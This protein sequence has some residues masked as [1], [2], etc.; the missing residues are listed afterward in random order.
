[1]IS[2]NI[3]NKQKDMALNILEPSTT[4][5]WLP[6][7]RLFASVLLLMYQDSI[8]CGEILC[9]ARKRRILP[10]NKKSGDSVSFFNQDPND[11]KSKLLHEL[12]S[13]WVETL[14]MV[15]DIPYKAFCLLII[16][17]LNT[18]EKRKVKRNR[19]HGA[20][21]SG[22]VKSSVKFNKNKK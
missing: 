13:E 8:F 3:F 9:G 5:D 2:D 6:E 18:K 15:T 10:K 19:P 21:N 12:N 22:K 20:S 16:D 14:C 7:K 17:A 11:I 4:Q 1:M